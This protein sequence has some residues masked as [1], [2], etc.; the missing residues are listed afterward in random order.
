M[1]HIV[2]FLCV[3]CVTITF[4]GQQKIKPE[5]VTVNNSKYI[6][7]SLKTFQF[8][9]DNLNDSVWKKEL[10]PL[11]FVEIP[12][13]HRMVAY[14]FEKGNTGSQFQI[15]SFD[16]AYG[17][18]SIFWNDA[19]TKNS[20]YDKVKN[21]FK[22]KPIIQSVYTTFKKEISGKNYWISYRSQIIKNRLEEEVT[23]EPAK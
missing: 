13:E 18:I 10:I 11:G 6:L 17:I 8:L 15:V 16:Q 19:T 3:G 9:V 20:L 14:Q 4:Y 7:P 22:G 23:L 21:Q 2:L 12:Q 1:K 5:Q